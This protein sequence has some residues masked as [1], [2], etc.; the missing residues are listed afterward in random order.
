MII[1]HEECND[2]RVDVIW[3]ADFVS[4]ACA[5]SFN[6]DPPRIRRTFFALSCGTDL[7]RSFLAGSR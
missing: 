5:I 4:V 7:L 3:P 2:V 6:V 1:R